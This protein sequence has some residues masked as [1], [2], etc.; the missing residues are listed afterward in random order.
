MEDSL[1]RSRGEDHQPGGGKGGGIVGL[2]GEGGLAEAGEG[3]AVIQQGGRPA[4]RLYFC[5]GQALGEPKCGKYF[6]LTAQEERVGD[7][8][9]MATN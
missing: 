3:L 7:L 1:T 2:A 9:K 6:V 5:P 4:G 8:L